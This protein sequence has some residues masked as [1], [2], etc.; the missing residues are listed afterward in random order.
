MGFFSSHW[1]T[2][3]V[4]VKEGGTVGMLH[5]LAHCMNLVR[6]V[7]DNLQLML[8]SGSLFNQATSHSASIS[9]LSHLHNIHFLVSL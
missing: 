2:H 3:I 4:T 6:V 7:K 5:Y 1:S 8:R 9:A